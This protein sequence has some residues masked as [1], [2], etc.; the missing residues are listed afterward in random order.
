MKAAFGTAKEA[1]L[2]RTELGKL[3]VKVE[4]LRKLPPGA[5]LAG[6]LNT[7]AWE[8]LYYL[9]PAQSEALALEAGELAEKL[10]LEGER[11]R[12]L[13]TM[14]VLKQ[15]TGDFREALLL[16]R[17]AMEAY[18]SVNDKRGMAAAH[19]TTGNIH[20]SQGVIEKALEHHLAS[21]KIKLETGASPDIIAH[22]HFNIGSCCLNL[23]QLE[24]AEEAYEQVRMTWENSGDRSRVAFLYNNMGSL[25]MKRGDTT[26]ALDYLGKAQAL[27]LE[28]GQKKN[29]AST[30]SAIGD[31]HR[32]TGD[33][34]MA[35]DC[36]SRSLCLYR[37]CEN[38]RGTAYTLC[39]TAGAHISLGSPELAAPLLEEALEISADGELREISLLCHEEMVN[40]EDAL[41]RFESALSWARKLMKLREEFL[42]WESMERIERLQL[43][44]DIEN[45][46][47]EAEIHRL[48]NV[49]LTRANR[50]LLEAL[51]HVKRLQSMLPICCNCK[52]IRDDSGYWEQIDL[53]IS[54]HSD[55]RFSHGICPDCYRK[56]YGQ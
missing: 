25:Y 19:G 41:G 42:N 37:E 51:E 28:L 17:K 50:E 53:Y 4:A 34:R 13:L 5:E 6:S 23:E 7:L 16:C 22:S 33:L 18:E 35:L 32:Q 40:L 21:L 1:D 2:D 31:L 52:K 9:E 46:E 38:T 49:E 12:S 14:A 43:Q 48:R 20:W 11:A 3:E 26:A 30:L 54:R 10:G 8:G 47:R 15:D 55:T 27:R 56:L 39:R 44:F 36:Y 29:A 24:R 45:T